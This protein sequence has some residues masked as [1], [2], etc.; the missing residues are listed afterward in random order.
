MGATGSDET[1]APLAM[2]GREV[3]GRKRPPLLRRWFT[4]QVLSLRRIQPA[5]PPL[6]RLGLVR[7]RVG[8]EGAAT[9][10]VRHGGCTGRRSTSSWDLRTCWGAISRLKG[11]RRGGLGVATPLTEGTPAAGAESD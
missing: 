6:P 9:V 5:P 8:G 4:E 2:C 1:P 3:A 10:P 11:R 7:L